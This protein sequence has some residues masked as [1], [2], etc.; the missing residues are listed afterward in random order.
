MRPDRDYS[1]VGERSERW[2]QFNASLRSHM[3]A[4]AQRLP[5]EAPM[6]I[7]AKLSQGIAEKLCRETWL[8]RLLRPTLLS[9]ITLER[10]LPTLKL[11]ESQFIPL[12]DRLCRGRSSGPRNLQPRSIKKRRQGSIGVGVRGRAAELFGINTRKSL[13]EA[14]GIDLDRSTLWYAY[15]R[16]NVCPSEINAPPAHRKLPSLACNP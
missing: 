12:G 16:T 9:Q 6:R 5:L 1:L 3:A 13:P 15:L 10:T 11:T 7:G 2:S 4:S 8:R 14:M